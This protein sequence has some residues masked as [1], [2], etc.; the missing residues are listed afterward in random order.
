MPWE[1]EKNEH[2]HGDKDTEDAELFTLS[3]MWLLEERQVNGDPSQPSG[4]PVE[5]SY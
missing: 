3:T 5:E 1:T 4:C 2:D